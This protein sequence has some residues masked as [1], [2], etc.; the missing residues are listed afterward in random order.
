MTEL[1]KKGDHIGVTEQSR[2]AVWRGARK[3]AEHA[4]DRRLRALAFEQ[5]KD[6]SMPVLAVPRVEIKIE[7]PYAVGAG[8]VVHNEQP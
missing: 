2:L 1:V 4:V 3:I 6:R 7:V 5:V 8:G